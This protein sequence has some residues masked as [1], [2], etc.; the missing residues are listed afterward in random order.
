MFTNRPHPWYFTS[1]LFAVSCEKD[2]EI[3]IQEGS[4]NQTKTTDF[5][6]ILNS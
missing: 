2:V 3:V 5:C 1:D 4:S 6:S